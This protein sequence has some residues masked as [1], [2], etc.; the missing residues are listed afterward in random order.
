MS[1]SWQHV[2]MTDAALTRTKRRGSLRSD[3]LMMLGARLGALLFA[4]ATSAA[5][6]RALGPSG[7]GAVSVGFSFTLLLAQIG[8]LGIMSANPYFAAKDPAARQ[9]IVANS[10][11]MSAILV[12]V[13]IGVG[14]AVEAIAPNVLQGLD[15]AALVVLF[16]GIPAALAA[17]FLQ[18]VLLGEGRMSAYNAI[19]LGI[20]LLTL[21]AVLVAVIGF[22]A[23]VLAILVVLVASRFLAALVYLGILV[24]GTA[25]TLAPDFSLARRM[26]KYGLR[27]YLATLMAFVV[28]RLDMLLVNGYLGN[29]QAGQYAVAV[30]LADAMYILPTVIAVNLFAHV[31]RGMGAE[32]SAQVFRSVGLVYA[33]VCAASIP[34]SILVIRIVY[35]PQFN[36]AIPL[37]WWLA[38]GI[39][40]LGMLT[41]LSQHFAGRGFPIQA[42]LVWFVGLG[43]NLAINLAF[44]HSGAYVAALA[45]TI[46]YAVL[47]ILHVRMFARE[48]GGLAKLRPRLGETLTMVRGGFRRARFDT[49]G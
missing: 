18:S 34:L 23:G 39:F 16:A 4:T 6:A 27:V 29:A 10:L 21:V 31:A 19:D 12:L 14:S 15:T 30:A 17:Q 45:S 28:I 42:A 7:R 35:G 1:P 24:R 2:R 11:W 8:G 43:V 37:Y 46:A 47:L 44:L 40:C 3:V 36:D 13:L 48:I 32:S 38:P 5:I 25:L 26:L 33:I 22:S 41:I 49:T 9:R 20:A